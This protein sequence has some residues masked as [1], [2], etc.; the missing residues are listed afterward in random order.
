MPYV[1]FASRLT[2]HKRRHRSAA[3]P[4]VFGGIRDNMT[5]ISEWFCAKSLRCIHIWMRMQIRRRQGMRANVN[6]LLRRGK[7]PQVVR[8]SA[9][10]Y[11]SQKSV[12]QREFG[13]KPFGCGHHTWWNA[14][15]CC[16]GWCRGKRRTY[17]HCTHKTFVRPWL[18]LF[19]FVF[20]C[21]ETFSMFSRATVGLFLF[22]LSLF[23]LF[24]R[25]Y[26]FIYLCPSCPFV[27]THLF[28][29]SH[30]VFNIILHLCPFIRSPYVYLFIHIC[31]HSSSICPLSTCLSVCLSVCPFL[32]VCLFVPSSF[33]YL[34][35]GLLD[36]CSFLCSLICTFFLIFSSFQ[37]LL[38]NWT[39]V[40]D[41]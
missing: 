13:M 5:S 28:I 31:L 12:L 34:F 20:K 18:A 19:A 17:L 15:K 39:P 30:P 11:L 29:C 9:K 7:L 41:I 23:P 36:L 8:P 10:R 32:S 3:F 2:R 14:A 1:D 25:S 40:Y 27:G 6:M 21:G 33:I 26:L 24:I 35:V 37:T 22:P 38:L 16:L 4:P